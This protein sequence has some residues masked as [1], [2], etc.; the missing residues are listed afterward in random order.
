MIQFI[1]NYL[2]SWKNVGV[3][4]GDGYSVSSG[5]I[6]NSSNMND[7]NSSNAQT[8]HLKLSNPIPTHNS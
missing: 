2:E 6:S 7:S 3:L 4:K 1:A 5:L 8:R